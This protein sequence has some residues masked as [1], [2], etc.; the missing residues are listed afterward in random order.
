VKCGIANNARSGTYELSPS[1]T[2]NSE[3]GC[4]HQV[5]SLN[6]NLRHVHLKIFR[7]HQTSESRVEGIRS[8]HIDTE[9]TGELHHGG[10][11]GELAVVRG[12]LRKKGEQVLLRRGGRHPRSS[13]VRERALLSK[14]G[15]GAGGNR[16]RA[17]GAQ[18]GSRAHLTERRTWAST[19]SIQRRPP[20][21]RRCGGSERWRS[22][23]GVCGGSEK[24]PGPAL[25]RPRS[26]FVTI[27]VRK[28]DLLLLSWASSIGLRVQ[29][30][31]VAH[32]LSDDE[33]WTSSS[34]Q[35]FVVT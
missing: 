18:G 19:G 2:L 34:D 29:A 4:Q 22:G 16:A 35:I 1:V 14:R 13:P 30:L 9:A 6:P 32:Q 25:I 3:H 28:Q 10:G 31:T 11:G 20:R 17:R 27:Y 12:L 21:R 8:T 33:S 5:I 24:A 7:F 26:I 23:I 15:G